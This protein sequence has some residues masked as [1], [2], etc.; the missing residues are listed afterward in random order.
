MIAVAKILSEDFRKGWRDALTILSFNLSLIRTEKGDSV[1]S[2]K[3]QYA[4]A[5]ES[6][7]QQA[8]RFS[9]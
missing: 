6:L 4:E 9:R 3:K 5:I 2:V 1:E 7:K 8:P